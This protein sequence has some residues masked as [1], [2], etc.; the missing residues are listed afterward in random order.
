VCAATYSMSH[1]TLNR[2]F[3][4][5]SSSGNCPSNCRYCD[6]NVVRLSAQYACYPGITASAN[7]ESDSH[8]RRT[9]KWPLGTR[10]THFQ[11]GTKFQYVVA[12]LLYSSYFFFFFFYY[13]IENWIWNRSRLKEL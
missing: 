2:Y 12:V 6:F 4:C 10:R 9:F 1:T 3:S 5:A 8:T 7:L 11:I 13:E